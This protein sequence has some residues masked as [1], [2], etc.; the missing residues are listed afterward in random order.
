MRITALLQKI[1]E[2]AIQAEDATPIDID[3]MLDYT[4]VLYSDLLDWRDEV[5]KPKLPVKQAEPAAQKEPVAEAQA[6]RPVPVPE[7]LRSAPALP[8]EPTLEEY[9]AAHAGM[10]IHRESSTQDGVPSPK[11]TYQSAL[12]LSPALVQEPPAATVVPA[13][14]ALTEIAEPEPAS[15]VAEPPVAPAPPKPARDI[16]SMIGINDKYQ[17]MSELF[18]NDKA[19]YEQALDM[20][21]RAESEQAAFNWL[22]ERLWVTEDH[23]DAAMIFFDVV[24]RFKNG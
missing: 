23:S 1:H 19:A 24:R 13:A 21:N 10:A 3:L 16:R 17:I 6:P 9:M 12:D 22:R 4:R 8:A 14:P 15:V 11:S 2:L 20:I 7:P 18:G 5:R